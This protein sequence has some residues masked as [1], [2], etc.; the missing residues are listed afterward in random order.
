M[1]LFD[2]I[3]DTVSNV[4]SVLD[5]FSGALKAGATL[6]G[7][8]MTNASNQSISQNQMQFQSA[9]T[10]QQQAFQERMSNTSYQ[11]AVSDLQAAGL[12]PMLAYSQG[13]ASTPSGAAATGAS[14]AMQNPVPAAVGAYEESRM[15]T[16]NLL[17][18]KAQK[19]ATE[20]AT[21]ASIASAK[22]SSADALQTI[23]NMDIALKRLPFEL[24][25]MTSR[26]R[27]N[28]ATEART[29]TGNSLD[30]TQLPG[31]LNNQSV[32]ESWFG[33]NIRPYLKDLVSGLTSA[34]AGADV[35]RGKPS[36]T[37]NKNYYG[38]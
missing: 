27:L 28:S 8:A 19:L 33:R 4:A 35:F 18:L 3:L 25:E 6:L 32:D 14:I 12:S 31:A 17:N 23:Q 10:A 11:R 29:I 30:K 26:T 37:F 9:Q 20:A 13:G 22:K 21:E 1:G 24:A 5:P 15:N 16:Q 2:G 34:K 7:G 36:T 38:R